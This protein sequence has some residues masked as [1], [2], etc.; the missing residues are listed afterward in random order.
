MRMTRRNSLALGLSLTAT[1]GI[2]LLA[3]SRAAP[4]AGSPPRV[5]V[6]LPGRIDDGGFMEAGYQGL[7][8]A[9]RKTGAT[10]TYKDRVE[11][12]PELLEAALREL[13]GS[14]PD[15]VAAHGGQNSEAAKR[16][17]A[18]FPNMAFVVVQGDITGPN[19]AS[20]EVLQEQSAWLG[21]ALAGLLTRTGTV[22]HISGIRVRPGLKGRGAFYHGLRATNQQARFLT[23]FNGSQ[24][25]VALA[26]RTAR[27]L[28]EADADIIFTMLNAARTGAIEACRQTGTRQIGNVVD[29][30]VVEPKIFVASA[31]ADVSRAMSLAIADFAAGRW[32][33]GRVV[34]IGLETPDAV[35][36]AMYPDT[37]V[38][39]RGRI[40]ELTRRIVAG[41][42]EVRTDYDG[43]EFALL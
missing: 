32:Q 12:K 4:A 20:Y 6:L 31:V 1:S 13:A 15:L 39:A 19:V 9:E 22:G 33:P 34:R 26:E 5:A 28:A 43:E 17:A 35:R 16:V 11:P 24:D 42:I 40:D 27:A 30:T 10:I 18:D 7:K 2:T 3:R 41:E 21:G 8:R 37:P 38:Q 23:I 29:W 25:D 36:L 14:D